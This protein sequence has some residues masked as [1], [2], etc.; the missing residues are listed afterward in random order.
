MKLRLFF[1]IFFVFV[2]QNS[3]AERFIP[4]SDLI[5]KVLGIVNQLYVDNKRVVPQ[6]ML[7]GSLD[8]L[9]TNI[10][11]VLTKLEL[12]QDKVVIQVSVD[13]FSKTFKFK[14]PSSIG[15][16]N[17][18]LQQI[19]KFV[20]QHLE[21]GEKPEYVDYAVINGFLTKLDPHSSLLIPEIYSDFSSSTS[22]NFGGVGMMIGLRDGALT[23]I[24][25][26]DDTPASRTGL[27]AKD[28]IVQIN[29]ESTINMSLTDAVKK[30]RGKKGTKVDIYIMREGFTSPKKYIITRDIIEITSVESYVFE[31]DNKRVGFLKINTFQQNTMDEINS[32]LEKLD[33]DLNDFQGLILDLRNNPGGLLDQAIK[34]CDRFLSDG[35]IVST[36]GLNPGSIKSYKAHWFPINIDIPIIL[37]VNNGSASAS[38]IV[39]AA[40]KK[41]NRGIVLGIQTFGKGSVQQV[42]PFKEGSALKLTTS[43]YLT[44][45]NISIQSVGVAPH[46]AVIPYF[47]SNDFLHVTSPKLDRAEKSLDQNFAEWGDKAEQPE[48]TIFYLFEDD[49][50]PASPDEE[51]E[52]KELKFKRF[53]ED[54]LVQT[55]VKTL[56]KNNRK[57]FDNLLK[58]ALSHVDEVQKIQEQKLIDTF[59]SFSIP[60]DWKRHQTSPGGRIESEIWLE[61]KTEPEEGKEVWKKH[62]GSIPADNEIR[63]YLKAKNI[64]KK[65]I[66]RLMAITESKNRIFHDRQFAFGRLDSGE[67]KQWYIPIKISKSAPSRNNLISFV[68]T[69]Q[70]NRKIYQ[71]STALSIQ[72]KKRP[73]F[74]YNISLM[75]NGNHQS[76]GNRDGTL[77]INETIAVGVA[78]TNK[79][80]GKSGSL[81]VLLKNGEGKNVFLKKGRKTL[82]PLPQGK[83]KVVYFQFDLKSEPADGDL[84]FSL[85]ILDGTFPLTSLNQKMKFPLHKKTS[86]FS[87]RPPSIRMNSK[88]LIS[89][90]KSYRFSGNIS[91]SQGVKDVYIFK[92]EKKIFYRNFMELKQRNRVDFS[93]N[94]DLEEENNKIV[95]ISRD[96]ENVTARKNVYLRYTESK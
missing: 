15:E 44:P 51:A 66:S 40:L 70:E 17:S 62:T 67:S 85:D 54:F 6:K 58:T 95:V 22:G 52:H 93:L 3:Y 65:R 68:F 36:A 87:N 13:Q 47:I 69:D 48:K 43:K 31:E 81:I 60:I 91:D 55:A 11:P 59:A 49:K 29:E 45:G 63:L 14:K 77:Q 12:N 73:E 8:K 19:V 27:K 23:I 35:V 94:I 33:Y 83:T 39:T 42:I 82:E 84:D 80:E 20:K 21:Q 88:S 71:D 30:L 7:K 16:L 10:A 57:H 2:F 90:K 79:G 26:I 53:K 76:R 78:V 72:E 25:P 56:I 46:I 41:N 18:I 38:E 92:N 75:E 86:E 64:G 5:K 89:S 96:D 9:S 28:R 24:A 61:I 74:Y 4:Q 50:K 32:H 34:V 37:L 1:V